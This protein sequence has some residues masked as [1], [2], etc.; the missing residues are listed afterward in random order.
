RSKCCPY[1]RSIGGGRRKALPPT[2]PRRTRFSP[3]IIERERTC[4]LRLTTRSRAIACW[5]RSRGQRQP[6]SV[7]RSVDSASSCKKNRSQIGSWKSSSASG[8]HYL[9]QT[10]TSKR[11]VHK[12]KT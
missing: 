2:S 8:K 1:Q 10:R 5:T 7:K 4:A 12:W 9:N 3:A 6:V 11:H